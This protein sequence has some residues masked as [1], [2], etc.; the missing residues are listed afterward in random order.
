MGYIPIYQ[1]VMELVE[2]LMIYLSNEV[3]FNL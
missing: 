3:F 2:I 1:Y